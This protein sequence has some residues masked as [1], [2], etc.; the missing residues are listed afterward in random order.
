MALLV[1]CGRF[2]FDPR[3]DGG[4]GAAD[5]ADAPACTF[6]PWGTPTLVSEVSSSA[7]DFGPALDADAL[8]LIVQSD[9]SGSMFDAGHASSVVGPAPD[10]WI[11]TRASTAD[12][13]STPVNLTSINTSFDEKSPALSADGLTLYLSTNRGSAIQLYRA[14][15]GSLAGAFGPPSLVTEL[16]AIEVIGATIS[17]D[18]SELFYSNDAL[19]TNVFRATFAAGTFTFAGPIAE[20]NTGQDQGFPSLSGDGRELYFETTRSDG[21]HT[22][23]WVA[24]RSGPGQPFA[25]IREVT[26][27]SVAGFSDDDPEIS[28]DG[29]TIVFASDRPGG[30]GGSDIWMATRACQ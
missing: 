6:G 17:S 25:D 20:L 27:L 22:D 21:A 9:R 30:L 29:L 3:A 26:A 14:T 8:T 11:S 2:G 18:G 24:T 12:P 1:G 4:P 28:R 16:G 10:L 13:F 5:A 23:V 7:D 19:P 15:R